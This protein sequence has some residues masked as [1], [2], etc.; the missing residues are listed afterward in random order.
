M[1]TVPWSGCLRVRGVVHNQGAASRPS[2]CDSQPA[3]EVPA[4]KEPKL[5]HEEKQISLQN[6]Q[7]NDQERHSGTEGTRCG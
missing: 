6:P 4:E 2:H 1:S 7:R 5:E 3:R